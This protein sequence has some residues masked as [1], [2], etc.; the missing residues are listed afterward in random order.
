MARQEE[1]I[2]G[3]DVGASKVAAVVAKRSPAGLT[4]VGCGFAP[5]V[6]D[7]Q[8]ALHDRVRRGTVI[9]AD[10]TIQAVQDAVREAEVS[11]G[12]SVHSAIVGIG[13]AHFRG[14]NSHGVIPVRRGEV[15]AEDIERVLDAARTIAFPAERQVLH[16]LPQNYVL[17]DQ[18]GIVDPLGMVG[19]RL[20]ARV[21]V[22]TASVSAVHNVIRC[23]Q[24]AGVEP[25]ELVW[26]PLA[27]A[28][29]LLTPDEKELG[30]AFWDLGA[31]TTDVLI[32]H[33]G[34]LRFS[35]SLGMG[36]ACITSDVAQGCHTTL[37]EAE[38]IKV[39]YGCALRSEVSEQE[40]VDVTGL[41]GRPPHAVPL[42]ELAWMIEARAEEILNLVWQEARKVEANQYTRCG[43]VIAG[44]GAMLSAIDRLLQQV[45][46][47]QV[48]VAR[49]CI[50]PQSEE[51]EVAERVLADPTYAAAVGLVAMHER[52]RLRPRNDVAA[53]GG[54]RWNRAW[55][56]VSSF[57]RALWE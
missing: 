20:E 11:A 34:G 28:E 16:V 14:V 35:Y 30:V 31:G 9:D 10:A 21:H 56:R 3:L 37:H 7:G 33:R 2:V 32:F 13:G 6:S 50:L 42:R 40:V 5:L 8:V 57:L 18:E 4:L 1:L 15:R 51:T 54:G 38:L 47:V 23:C 45:S 52:A 24:R 26:A 17:D 53:D 39:R 19:V 12:C 29:A 55:S 44:G 46:G 36:G 22:V 41:G 43:A 49:R 48:R 25:V 27:A